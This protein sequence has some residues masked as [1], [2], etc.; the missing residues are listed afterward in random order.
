MLA[1]GKLRQEDC[2]F[3][4]SLG[5]TVKPC[6]KK[7]GE[8][9]RNKRKIELIISSS[10]SYVVG[11]SI[12]KNLTRGNDQLVFLVQETGSMSQLISQLITRK[13][14]WKMEV[15]LPATIGNNSVGRFR[16]Q[17]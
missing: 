2:K 12:N 13:K 9:K 1:F 14:L 10:K 3:K 7:K 4:S 16:M 15:L 11:R 8:K 5:Y 17:H 6:L